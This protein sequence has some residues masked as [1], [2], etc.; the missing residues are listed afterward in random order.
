MG[1]PSFTINHKSFMLSPVGMYI[2]TR[3]LSRVQGE[4]VSIDIF[5]KDN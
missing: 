4:E 2:G 1:Y 5:Y 3:K